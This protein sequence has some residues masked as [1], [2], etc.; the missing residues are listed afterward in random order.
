MNIDNLNSLIITFALTVLFLLIISALFW[1]LGY[2]LVLWLRN[3]GREE[4]SLNS[5][6]LQISLPRE[7]EIKIDA[8]EQM[9]TSLASMRQI[10]KF[11]FFKQQPR[12]SFEIVGM[13]GDIRFY[14]CVPN[15][16]RDFVEKQINGACKKYH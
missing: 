10:G 5:T 15:K 9:F 4:E 3:R 1:L 12:L 13:P 2:V 11:E 14:V 16:Y 8:A 7:N 6:I